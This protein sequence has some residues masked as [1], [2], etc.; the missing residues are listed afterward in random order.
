MAG[1][2]SLP[3]EIRDKIYSY[4]VLFNDPLFTQEAIEDI[5]R[6]QSPT[7]HTFSNFPVVDLSV[8]RVNKQIH[9]EA[10][11]VFYTQNVFS[12][13][14]VT[15]AYKSYNEPKQCFRARWTT[16]WEDIAY[17][18]TEEGGLGHFCPGDYG[19]KLGNEIIQDEVKTYIYPSLRY[20]HLLRKIRIEVIDTC[21]IQ[22]F[23]QQNQS[24]RRS[25]CVAKRQGLKGLLRGTGLRKP[26]TSSNKLPLRSIFM[27]LA[28]RLRCL[29]A[30]CNGKVKVDIKVSSN[31]VENFDDLSA[32]MYK[33]LVEL[34]SPF[35]QGYQT[36]N[37]DLQI[38]F[39][40]EYE[41]D[42]KY[43]GLKE[44]VLKNCNRDRRI[45]TDGQRF[46][47]IDVELMLHW[48]LLKGR[49]VIR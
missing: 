29:L 9:E 5:C 18:F 40:E 35:T 12:V 31:M 39:E 4:T 26:T 32:R 28:C 36:A 25:I 3:R 42:P 22:N 13:K 41:F 11:L 37:I 24:P 45:E 19:G 23:G 2:L 48:R 30:A 47:D 27:P 21:F 20:R 43:E 15:E 7:V 44:K 17:E 14:V 49:L 38:P 33:D 10:S 6:R 1:F 16:P 8:L 46:E 34:A